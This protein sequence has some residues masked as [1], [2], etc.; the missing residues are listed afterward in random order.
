MNDYDT[1]AKY[2]SSLYEKIEAAN[3][4]ADILSIEFERINNSA[5][6]MQQLNSVIKKNEILYDE[7]KVFLAKAGIAEPSWKADYQP[8]SGES[9]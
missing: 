1:K 9:L 8:F 3:K 6:F 4:E 7:W 5:T 2:I